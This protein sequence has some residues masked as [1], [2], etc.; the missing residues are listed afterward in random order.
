MN[1]YSMT[2]PN[3]SIGESAYS[4]IPYF[5][6]KWGSTAVMIGGKTAMQ[7][8]AFLI[9][10]AARGIRLTGQLWYGGEAI[11]KQALRWI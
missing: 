8:A 7:K 2:L 10:K 4:D 9:A 11:S 6:R 5:C 3:Y 1:N